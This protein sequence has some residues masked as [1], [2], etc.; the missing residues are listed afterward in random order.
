MSPAVNRLLIHGSRFPRYSLSFLSNVALIPSSRSPKSRVYFFLSA[1][2][3]LKS[4]VERESRKN[5][6]RRV[7]FE[8]LEGF[9]LESTYGF[10][11]HYTTLTPDF[12]VNRNLLEFLFTL[13]NLEIQ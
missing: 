10:Q 9:L 5:H 8:T 1:R 4:W 6:A 3:R 11:R 2:G 7:K 12:C 13:Q